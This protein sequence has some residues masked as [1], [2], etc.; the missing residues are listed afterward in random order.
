MGMAETDTT[1]MN[2]GLLA[3]G[4]PETREPVLAL[5]IGL[6]LTSVFTLMAV[7]FGG[8]TAGLIAIPL[9]AVVFLLLTSFDLT[10]IALAM[11]FFVKTYVWI[12]S[13][14]VWFSIMVAA[15]FLLHR[16]DFA[17]KDLAHPMTI[18]I[19]VY[20]LCVLPSFFNAVNPLMSAVK[21]F[22]VLA[23]LI[24]MYL[25]ASGVRSRD[26]IR[27]VVAAFL[28]LALLN[29]L[30]VIIGAAATG[31]RLYGFAGLMYVDYAGLAVSVTATMTLF[32]HG[33]RRI[34]LLLLSLAI[35][36]ALILTQTRSTWLATLAT[37]IFLG[38]YLILHPEVVGSTR[39]R[40]MVLLT[41]GA[42]AIG[43]MAAGIVAINPKIE[44][45]VA[46]LGESGGVEL[47]PN[48]AQTSSLITR[49]LI[50]DTAIRAFS[51]HPIT[52]IGVYGF[53]YASRQYA[54]MPWFLYE[55]Y[56]SGM[57]PHQTHFAALVETGILGWLG[58]LVFLA[59]IVR[60]ATR[61]IRQVSSERGRHF[62][63]AGAVA[64]VYCVSSMFF[65]D[66][67]LWGQGIVLLGLVL[68]LVTANARL[69]SAAV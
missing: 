9:V 69:E 63:L 44:Q 15:A 68:G 49:M 29:G 1:I 62:A 16:R 19:A 18:P 17:W 3:A 34:L 12:F 60:Y 22:N 21:L 24:V 27:R 5:V 33:I 7:L 28:A 6:A 55:K 43:V 61:V 57:S 67:W 64:V 26:Q 41:V 8:K 59:S 42:L 50:W 65:T 36:G 23:F 56:V 48:R 13:G 46:N 52:G 30:D 35:S 25:T 11:V 47:D 38:G 20:G 51:E 32:A 39:R 4:I 53:S 66:A 58:L 40:V 37:L 14:A 10:L 31:K 45:R 54:R 2:S